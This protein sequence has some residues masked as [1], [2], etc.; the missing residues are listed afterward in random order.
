MTFL[1][2][3]TIGICAGTALVIVF[4]G[5]RMSALADNLADR[6]GLGEALTG[7]VFLGAATSLPGI[8]ASVTAAHNGHASL[9]LS[10]AFGG[11][12]AQTAFLALADLAY[13]RANLEHAAASL[14]NILAGTLLISLLSVILLGTMGP[15]ISF[16]GIHPITPLLFAA[17]VLGLKLIRRSHEYPMWQPK[18]TPETRPDIPEDIPSDSPALWKIWLQFAV[19]AF[20]V[21]GAGWLLTRASETIVRETGISESLVGAFLIAIITSLPE[22]VTTIAAVRRGALTLAVGG[23]LGGNT[24][25]ILFGAMADAAYRSG[26]IYHAANQKETI[27]L[28]LSI[29][30]TSILIIGLLVRQ[31]RGIANI[32]FESIF[33]LFIYGLGILMIG[34]G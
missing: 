21:M 10:N 16:W 1:L 28:P 2:L 26:S 17:Y 14:S 5:N 32:G 15:E 29:L 23:V 6:S 11:I 20:F 12:A 9:A 7:T 18:M 3:K 19:S 22:L 24:F 31:K 25:D 34:I 27:L 30:M 13:P 33:V 4:A 8:T